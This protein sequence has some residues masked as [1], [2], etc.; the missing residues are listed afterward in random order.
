MNGLG[1]EIEKVNL[2]FDITFFSDICYVEAENGKNIWA[3]GGSWEAK[4]ESKAFI[5]FISLMAQN[6][7]SF[8]KYLGFSFEKIKVE[9]LRVRLYKKMLYHKD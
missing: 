2:T 8:Y 6:R 9:N 3:Q 5:S 4:I 7:W 1:T